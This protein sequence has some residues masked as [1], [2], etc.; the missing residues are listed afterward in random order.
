MNTTEENQVVDLSTFAEMAGFPVELIK[1]EL[2][3]SDDNKA[4]VSLAQLRI[5]MLSYL[6]KAMLQE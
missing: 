1:S 4:E 6:D 3:T 5:A 2:F